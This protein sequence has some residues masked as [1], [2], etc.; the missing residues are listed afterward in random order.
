MEVSV[1]QSAVSVFCNMYILMLTH[2]HIPHVPAGQYLC[3]CPQR[4]V[5]TSS[6]HVQN[7]PNATWPPPPV[8]PARDTLT[9]CTKYKVLHI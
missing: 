2:R 4:P 1:Q 6:R 9:N 3:L 8:T 5:D 7:M